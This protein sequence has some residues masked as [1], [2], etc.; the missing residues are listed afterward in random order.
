MD[1]STR[2]ESMPPALG[3][4]DFGRP[5]AN[6]EH[7]T[8]V[9]NKQTPLYRSC[10]VHPPISFQKDF[11]RGTRFFIFGQKGVGKTAFLRVLHDDLQKSGARAEYIVFNDQIAQDESIYSPED[12]LV[13]RQD[14]S[15][16][17]YHLHS[18][19]RILMAILIRMLEEDRKKEE[20]IRREFGKEGVSLIG[21]IRQASPEELVRKVCDEIDSIV[22]ST[23]VNVGSKSNVAKAKT[24]PEQLIKRRNDAL[25]K[26]LLQSLKRSTEK[27]KKYSI[28]VDEIQYNYS[29]DD[30][31]RE[32]ATLVR[33]MIVAALNLNRSFMNNEVDATIY[34]A[35]RSEF[36]SHPI[37]AKANVAQSIESYGERLFWRSNTRDQNDP[38]L[39]II[40]RRM[41]GAIR[42]KFENSDL[43]KYYLSNI[44]AK[45]F[46]SYT[47][48]KPRD[49]IRFFSKAREM[50]PETTTLDRGQ[51]N[52][53]LRQYS[54]DCW[55]DLKPAAA[56]LFNEAGLQKLHALLEENAGH[57]RDP[58]FSMSAS[59]F[60]EKL[61]PLHATLDKEIKKTYT[62]ESL[63]YFLFSIGIFY[64]FI[65]EGDKKRV[66]FA[67]LGHQ[68]P[69]YNGHIRFHRTL[70][71]AFSK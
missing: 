37:I 57:F 68:A 14:I 35:I 46:I 12:I 54:L 52:D 36:L 59:K 25:L 49:V 5:D 24:N 15:Q 28:F 47:W 6:A 33:D 19:K 65:Q 39:S 64:S 67:C 13:R 40:T 27:G 22:Q 18:I 51:L 56:T 17:T 11:D 2:S 26:E 58:R 63:F 1:Q 7:D 45:D 9:R 50:F 21:R 34:L 70:V 55:Q 29:D 43:F 71:L 66:S 20:D 38:L 53:V 30:A 62:I 23:K 32:G 44:S 42:T 60:M 69:Y 16:T 48:R 4:I 31:Y 3:E 8:A 61:K 10:F 41:K